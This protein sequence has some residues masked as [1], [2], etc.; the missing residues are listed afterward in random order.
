MR[1]KDENKIDA[2]RECALE[3]IVEEGF[4]GLSMQKLA[5]AANVSPATIYIYYKDRDDLLHQLYLSVFDAANEAALHRF[6]PELPFAD[7]LKILWFNRCRYF[8]KHPNH[9][10]FLDQFVNSPMISTVK[11]QE[12]AHY[13]TTMQ[14]FY[15]N[16]VKRG[17]INEL[18]LDV[19]W[20]VA[21]APLYQ[22]I[23]FHLQQDRNA[24]SEKSVLLCLEMVLKALLI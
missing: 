18:P 7:G 2:I 16:A 21:F 17:E 22:L 9:A 6:N 13:R 10:L 8:L 20:S 15:D 19:Y 4:K 14:Q 12:N 11:D 1:T 23:R 5:K 3:M 24:M